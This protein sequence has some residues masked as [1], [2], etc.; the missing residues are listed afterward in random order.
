MNIKK[1]L[2]TRSNF[3]IVVIEKLQKWRIEKYVNL[4]WIK[5]ENPD[6]VEVHKLK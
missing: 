1:S 2:A 6:E 5:L 4:L 3:F